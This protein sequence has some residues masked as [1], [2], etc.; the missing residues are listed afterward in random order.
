MCRPPASR[1]PWR[2]SK[3]SS[4]IRDEAEQLCRQLNERFAG[5]DAA[6]VAFVEALSQQR[7]FPGRGGAP[8]TF[9]R[10]KIRLT[11][12]SRPAHLSLEEAQQLIDLGES[13]GPERGLSMRSE[14]RRVGKE[15]RS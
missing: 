4:V 5:P 9:V 10:Y 13:G 15:W 14:E 7:E 12:G 11:D 8:P 1:W 6:E 3:R 2:R